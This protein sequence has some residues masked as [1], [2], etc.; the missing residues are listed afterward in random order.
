MAHECSD[1]MFVPDSDTLLTFFV[2]RELRNSA[3]KK[4]LFVGKFTMPG[5]AGHSGFY[6]FRCPYCDDVCVDYP[7]GYRDKGCLYIQCDRCGHEIVFT[8][9]KYREIYKRENVVA[10]PTFWEELRG[11]WKLRKQMKELRK[12]VAK[13]ED[14]HGV[15]VV[16]KQKNYSE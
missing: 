9:G 12:G 13:I 15:K 8:P 14:E 1:C 3:G 5:W 16:I 6:L 7:H 4:P 11:S 10:P 2:P